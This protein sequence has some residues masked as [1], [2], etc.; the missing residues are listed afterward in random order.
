VA[1]SERQQ[2][3]QDPR[4]TQQGQRVCKA[5]SE[6]VKWKRGFPPRWIIEFLT[7]SCM[8]GPGTSMYSF[9]LVFLK[10]SFFH[11]TI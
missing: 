10:L 9:G 6:R 5:G 11:N 8:Q 3:V 4:K 1:A 2:P 7:F